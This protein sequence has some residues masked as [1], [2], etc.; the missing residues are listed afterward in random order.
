MARPSPESSLPS[1]VGSPPREISRRQV[2]KCV[3]VAGAAVGLHQAWPWGA[4]AAV[5]PASTTTAWETLSSAEGETLEAIVARLIPADDSGPGAR[6][7]GA[8]PFIDRA[9]RGGLATARDAYAVGLVAL[10]QHARSTRGAAFARL[11]APQQDALL[12]DMEKN[13]VP[14]FPSGSAEF[15]EL[16]RFHTI[17]GTFSDPHYGGNADFIGWKMIGYPGIRLAVGP[18]EQRIEI[19]L[20]PVRRSAYEFEMFEKASAAHGH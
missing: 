4:N 9:L 13:L 17:L 3:A 20:E 11:P 10:D 2:L 6:E 5:I 8:V 7:A 15:F 12:G 19:T 18:E 14:G 16:L 1:P